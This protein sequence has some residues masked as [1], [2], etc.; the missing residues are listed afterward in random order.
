[1][2][3]RSGDFAKW[4]MVIPFCKS[5]ELQR[6]FKCGFRVPEGLPVKISPEREA[7]GDGQLRESGYGTVMKSLFVAARDSCQPLP[8]LCV[9]C[10]VFLP[11][12]AHN[13]CVM[14]QICIALDCPSPG[15]C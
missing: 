11:C 12:Y 1:M 4:T 9:M 15:G 8:L 13:R 5:A 3:S 6:L 10:Y 2:N 14:R 7:C